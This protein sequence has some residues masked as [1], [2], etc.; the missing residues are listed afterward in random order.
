MSEDL[1]QANLPH[2]QFPQTLPLDYKIV[3]KRNSPRV[4]QSTSD[5]IASPYEPQSD[6]KNNENFEHS[7]A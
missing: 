1:R 7:A 2:A 5:M 3:D 6:Y 4:R